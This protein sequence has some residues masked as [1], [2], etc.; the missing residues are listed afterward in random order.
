MSS[1]VT[2]RSVRC[3]FE[4]SGVTD[5]S[6]RGWFE[7]SSGDKGWMDGSGWTGHRRGGTYYVVMLPGNEGVVARSG[8]VEVHV[9]PWRGLLFLEAMVV[10][11]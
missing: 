10:W 9:K 4:S 1:G 8:V 3:W 7:S 6:V 11:P 2:D 5:R